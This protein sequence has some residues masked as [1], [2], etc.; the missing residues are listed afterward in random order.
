MPF[1]IFVNA[2]GGLP[3]A[4]TANAMTTTENPMFFGHAETDEF[5]FSGENF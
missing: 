2:S 4:P 5:V 3:S 1:C